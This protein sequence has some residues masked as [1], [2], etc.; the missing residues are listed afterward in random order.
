MIIVSTTGHII[1]IIHPYLAR[2]NDAMILKHF[3]ETSGDDLIELLGDDGVILADRDFRDVAQFLQ[4]MGIKCILPSFLSK[5]QKAMTTDQANETRK[6]T[7]V[8]WVVESAIGRLKR[9]I[10]FRNTV[11]NAALPT[12]ALDFRISAALINK[13]KVPLVTDTSISTI[14]ASQMLKMMKSQNKLHQRFESGEINSKKR[15]MWHKISTIALVEFPILTDSDLRNLCFGSFQ[16][17]QGR[18]YISD[19]LHNRGSYQILVCNVETGLIQVTIQSR[20]RSAKKWRVF[21]RFAPEKQVLLSERYDIDI[22]VHELSQM[23]TSVPPNRSQSP[24]VPQHTVETDN[25]TSNS[26]SED[27]FYDEEGLNDDQNGTSDDDD[28]F[29]SVQ[30]SVFPSS[31][32]DDIAPAFKKIIGWYCTCLAGSRTVGM[33]SHVASI[34]WYLGIGRHQPEKKLYKWSKFFGDAKTV[35]HVSEDVSSDSEESE[36]EPNDSELTQNIPGTHEIVVEIDETPIQTQK[37]RK[38]RI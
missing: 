11:P 8:R 1:D 24:H 37:R 33:C 3:I 18:H 25:D 34:I 26:D 9:N 16:V 35:T 5:N 28:Q 21:V 12:I 4:D 10:L 31:Q 29:E 14:W 19:Q 15:S 6:L 38:M 17:N 20:H 13:F 32:L 30:A 23:S 22:E 36:I 7:K 27:D 2:N